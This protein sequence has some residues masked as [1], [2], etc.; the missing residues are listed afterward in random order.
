MDN[1]DLKKYLVESK[2]LKENIENDEKLSIG[3]TFKMNWFELD[4]GKD[5]VVTAEV[6]RFNRLTTTLR[7]VGKGYFTRLTPEEIQNRKIS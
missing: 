4:G 3:D 5:I 7:I 6:I 2:L 1:F